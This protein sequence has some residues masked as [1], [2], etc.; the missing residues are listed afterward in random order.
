MVENKLSDYSSGII[1]Y[2]AAVGIC[3]RLRL[4]HQIASTRPGRVCY[5][6]CTKLRR[7][8]STS[9]TTQNHCFVA[10]EHGPAAVRRRC[11]A[12]GTAQRFRRAT[13]WPFYFGPTERNKIK[14][15]LRLKGV[16]DIISVSSFD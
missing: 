14:I 12:E 16:C 1:E 11:M 4:V 6:K 10:S 7:G 9:R 5:G 2:I 3:R 13:P 8:G 15:L